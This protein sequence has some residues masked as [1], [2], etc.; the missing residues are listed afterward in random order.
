M[1]KKRVT[2]YD[3]VFHG[4]GTVKVNATIHTNPS[5]TPVINPPQRI[6]HAIENEVRK[7]LERMTELG[8]IVR[9]EEPTPWVNSVTIVKNP[10]ISSEFAQ[11]RPSLTKRS[12]EAPTP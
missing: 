4:L 5:V 10:Q 7:E 8:V 2:N 3:T 11:I 1:L 9:Q 12:Y 6:P